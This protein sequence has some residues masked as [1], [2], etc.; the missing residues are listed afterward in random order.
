[1]KVLLG[2]LLVAVFMSC[3]GS[4]SKEEAESDNDVETEAEQNE[5]YTIKVIRDSYSVERIKKEIAQKIA[6]HEQA[7]EEEESLNLVGRCINNDPSAITEIIAILKGEDA[8]KRTE[9]YNQMYNMMD[10]EGTLEL[11]NKAVLEAFWANLYRPEDEVTIIEI[12]G[13]SSMEGIG[14]QLEAF[15]LSG[16]LH[17]G[18]SVLY[19]LG[20][21]AKSIKAL[22]YAEKMI[23]DPKATVQLLADGFN[24]LRGFAQNGSPSIQK[25]VVKFCSQAYE[26]GIVASNNFLVLDQKNE[27]TNPAS[28]LFD[29]LCDYGGPEALSMLKK[30]PLVK[31]REHDILKALVRL[32]GDVHRDTVIKRIRNREKFDYTLDAAFDLYKQTKD[33]TILH[34]VLVGLGKIKDLGAYEIG[35]VADKLQEVN[36]SHHLSHLNQHIKSRACVEKIEIINSIRQKTKKQILDELVSEGFMRQTKADSLLKIKEEPPEYK[37]YYGIAYDVLLDADIYARL[38]GLDD[39]EPFEYDYVVK[40][41]M[42]LAHDEIGSSTVWVDTTSLE[43]EF[44]SYTI[45]VIIG[46]K[47]FV[48]E[49]KS[50]PESN[51]NVDMLHALMDKIVEESKTEKE[52]YF[53][54]KEE[55]SH[56]IIVVFGPRDKC[57]DLIQRYRLDE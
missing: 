16:K 55:G 51:Y 32:E 1:M 8:E 40:N 12:A 50:T 18:G 42:K 13:Y 46:N 11:H 52:F 41:L 53:T 27:D 2:L 10:Y 44:Y 36:A 30:Y 39:G 37:N 22:E 21:D 5:N 56:Q 49:S 26:K 38:Y 45:T 31:Q 3:G 17:E 33:T 34:E 14:K 29:I 19:W 9:V 23:M 54:N 43:G 20:Q 35:V 6:E 24:C 57:I 4:A 28:A 48:A 15:L 25:R 7:Q 47:V